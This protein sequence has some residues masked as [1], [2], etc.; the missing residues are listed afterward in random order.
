M[1]VREEDISRALQLFGIPYEWVEYIPIGVMTDKFVFG[2]EGSKYIARCY[3]DGR[4]YLAEAEYQYMQKFRDR[5]M[6]CPQP[7][8]IINVGQYL[9]L[10][11]EMLE[12]RMLSEV[13]THLS[14]GQKDDVCREIADNYMRISEVRSNGYGWMLGYEKFS[15]GSIEDL[16]DGVVNHAGGWIM[17]Y[18]KTNSQAKKV[19]E[20]FKQKAL[21]IEG[22]QPMLAWSELSMDNIIVDERVRLVGFVDFEG[23]MGADMNLGVGYLQAHENDSDFAMRLMKMM[24]ELEEE[25]VEFYAMMRYLRILPN[26]HLPLPNGTKRENLNEYM[27]YVRR[28]L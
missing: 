18:G 6:L 16:V 5:G 19:L 27:P 15:H 25:K 7:V 4:G 17:Q 12:G 11:Y 9:C 24:P 10:I 14:E 28:H 20:K 21:F 2:S 22:S 26:T 23:L 13:Y 8:R 1:F 3:P